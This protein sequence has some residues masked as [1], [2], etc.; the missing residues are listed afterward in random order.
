MKTNVQKQ[1]EITLQRNQDTN[2]NRSEGASCRAAVKNQCPL[3]EPCFAISCAKNDAIV[4]NVHLSSPVEHIRVY[5]NG[6]HMDYTIKV[7]L[8]ILPMSSY[9]NNNSMENILSPK[10]VVN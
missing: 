5:S 6:G 1:Q 3:L 8:N 2:W 7:T 10:E 4:S 9:V